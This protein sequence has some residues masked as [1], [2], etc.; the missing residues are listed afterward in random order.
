MATAIICSEIDPPVC[1]GNRAIYTVLYGDKQA[2]LKALEIER[3]ITGWRGTNIQN[4][5]EAYLGFDEA[6][7]LFFSK[8]FSEHVYDKLRTIETG[9]KAIGRNSF[10]SVSCAKAAILRKIYDDFNDNLHAK[11]FSILETGMK[12]HADLIVPASKYLPPDNT[13]LRIE[14]KFEF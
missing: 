13:D 1:V 5:F 4:R 14:G 10:D 11:D 2:R 12:L 3:K 8:E 6:L 7:Y 9:D